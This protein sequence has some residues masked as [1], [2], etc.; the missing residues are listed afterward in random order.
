MKIRNGFVSN[1]SSSSFVLDANKCSVMGV[2][3]YMI[4]T[5]LEYAKEYYSNED[6]CFKDEKQNM[7]KIYEIMKI[8]NIG[9]NDAI[10]FDTPNYKT[11]V[12]KYKD[13]I[14]VD[15]CNNINWGRKH[16]RRLV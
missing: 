13:L 9:L 6:E 12:W 8:N 7:N 15:T 1:S 16:Q 3:E 11:Y 5:Y 10:M 2:V 4:K 14:L